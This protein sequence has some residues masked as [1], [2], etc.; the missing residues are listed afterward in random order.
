[1]LKIIIATLAAFL[2]LLAGCIK[3]EDYRQKMRDFVIGISSYAKEMK[4]DFLI[5]PQNGH[6][7]LLL[8]DGLSLSY[9]KSIDGVGRED[10]FYGYEG[11]NLPTPEPIRKEMI[12]YMDIAESHGVEVLVT[13]YCWT[14]SF[15]DDS[16]NQSYSRG[17]ISFA[18]ERRELDNIPSYPKEPFNVNSKKIFSL[19]E[20]KNF[21]Y[22]I[23][24]GF[25][26]RR[27]YL[28]SI[29]N[30]NYDLIIVDLFYEGIAL[31][32]E[33]VESLKIKAN[34]S[35]R[36]VV[37]YMSIGEAEDY[38]YYWRDEWYENPPEWI[39]EENPEWPG[40]YKVR[41]WND[42]WQGIIYRNNDSYLRKII[43]AGFDGVYLDSIDSY[44]F[45]ERSLRTR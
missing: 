18:A 38:R 29:R 17:Y 41:Y 31:T 8:T 30:T 19:K 42:T 22:L 39:E 25:P 27:S 32:P 23:N 26:D 40:N 15:I 12:A 33:E 21:L 4:P 35:P 24:P 6:E 36:L 10:L 43:D 34:G 5:I 13:D 37:A 16:Y 20:A 1:M 44:E 9:I 45:F 2:I 14:H 3:K 11:D 28:D 7:L